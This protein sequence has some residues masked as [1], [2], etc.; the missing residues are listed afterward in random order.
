[1]PEMNTPLEKPKSFNMDY[2][3]HGCYGTDDIADHFCDSSRGIDHV[4]MLRE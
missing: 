4:A 3:W 2:S 1:M